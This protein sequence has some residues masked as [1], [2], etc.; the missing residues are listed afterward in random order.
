V[1]DAQ[2]FAA[3]AAWYDALPKDLQVAFD[4]ASAKTQIDT[5]AQ[6]AP[7]R[8][9]SMKL[10]RDG[11]A[12]FYNPTPAEFKQWVDACGEQR[13]E[14]DEH[15][16]KLAGSIASFEKLKAAANTKGPITVGD[17]TG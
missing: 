7:A 2:M 10:M 5:F 9:V 11:G 15:K 12:Q 3:N 17:Y 8:E 6:I 4:A 16:I 14:W 1:P 13:K